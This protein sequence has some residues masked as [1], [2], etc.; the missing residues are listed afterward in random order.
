MYKNIDLSS[1]IIDSLILLSPL[2]VHHS[3]SLQLKINPS[4]WMFTTQTHGNP[5]TSSPIP[6]P[7]VNSLP[8]TSYMFMPCDCGN[9]QSNLSTHSIP[10]STITLQHSTSPEIILTLC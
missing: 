4:S 7:H 1:F 2:I 3:A 9:C 5:S 10:D 8:I 6:T